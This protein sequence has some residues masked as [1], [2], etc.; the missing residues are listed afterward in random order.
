MTLS[1]RKNFDTQDAIVYGT[2]GLSFAAI[3]LFKSGDFM[4]GISN[5][6]RI[7]ENAQIAA[8]DNRV[9]EQRFGLGCNTGFTLADGSTNLID[10][11]VPL[12]AIAKT[13]I[14]PGA[15]L[16]DRTGATAIVSP[17]GLISD[18]RVSARVRKTF[19]DKGLGVQ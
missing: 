3:L 17:D 11:Q 7:T 6:S 12:D 15:V 8:K 2:L 13:P 16:C 10:G 9:A 18:I 19:I 4:K 5:Q 14:A 1:K